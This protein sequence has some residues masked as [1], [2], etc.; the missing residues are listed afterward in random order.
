MEM[1]NSETVTLARDA[2]TLTIG[3]V[4]TNQATIRPDAIAVAHPGGTLSFRELDEASSRLANSLVS[5]GV[6]PGERIAVLS[7]NTVELCVLLYAAAKAGAIVAVVNWRLRP[8]EIAYCIDLIEAKIVC[9]SD[10]RAEQLAAAAKLLKS[11]PKTTR[12]GSLAETWRGD[13]MLSESANQPSSGPDIKVD[14]ESVLIILYTSGTTGLPKA[15]AISHRALIA[16]AGVMAAELRL[17]GDDAFIGWA[18]MFHQVSTDYLFV[19]HLYG[20]KFIVLPGFDPDAIVDWLHRERIGWLVLMPGVIDPI[21]NRLE[22]ESKRVVGVRAVGAMADLVPPDQLR[23]LTELLDAPYFNSFGCTET[24]AIPSAGA[25]LEMGVAPQT[26]AKEQSAF[27]DVFLETAEGTCAP[28]G[29][30]GELALRGP[31]MFSGYWNDDAATKAAFRGGW[32]RTGDLF[33]RT[34]TGLLD[35]VARSK[36]MIKSGGE[37]IYPAEI[38][39][40]LMQHPSIIEVVVVRRPDRKWGEVPVA[41]VAMSEA[42]VPVSDIES[43][44]VER[45]ANYKRPKEIQVRAL[46][47]F[48]RSVTGK[49]LREVLELEV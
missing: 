26:F 14:S 28:V 20:G 35:F 25:L 11:Q 10:D 41:V 30:V 19:T 33:K 13:T 7:E 16:R 49:V 45:L 44:C 12:L 32:F 23:R 21:I 18:P 8:D 4:I 31:T 42:A 15:V 17:C 29:T 1:W 37:N 9:Y 2:S 34:D 39:R 24:G 38:E 22:R 47:E 6:A 36:Y 48:P 43:F 3:R 46:E 27:C 40:V 5:A